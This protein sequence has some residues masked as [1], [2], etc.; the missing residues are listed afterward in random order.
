[1]F[2]FVDSHTHAVMV[3]YAGFQA[4]ADGGVEAAISCSVLI[5]ARHAESYFDHFRVNTGFYRKV[6]ASV[7]LKLLFAAGVHPLGIPGDWTQVVDRLPEFLAEEGTVAI[8]E[9]GMNQASSLEQDVLRAQ[10]EVAR[11]AGYP[12]ILHTPKENREFVVGK[13]LEIAARV[14]NKPES[15]IID[16][17]NVDIIKQINDFGAVPGLTIRRQGFTPEVLCDNLEL[18]AGGVLNSDYSNVM[19]NDPAAVIWAVDIMRARGVDSAVAA[20]MAGNRARRIFGL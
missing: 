1:M 4:M 15:L 17:A 16:H 19:P 11:D 18:F 7:G 13:L 14:G 6:A 3:P 20:E 5:E 2:K 8:G 9:I 10:L 12:V